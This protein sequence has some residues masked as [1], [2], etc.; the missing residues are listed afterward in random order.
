VD[1]YHL[2]C[3]VK[4]L[5][6]ARSPRAEFTWSCGADSFEPIVLDGRCVR[7]FREGADKARGILRR[8]VWA[9]VPPEAERDRGEILAAARE[10]A[11][12]G[13]EFYCLI[14]PDDG[15]EADVRGWLEEL[16]RAGKVA[17]IE[18]VCD[19]A[20]WSAPWNLVYGRDPEEF[21]FDATAGLAP[22]EPFWGIGYNLASGLPVNPLRSRPLPASP[23]VLLVIDPTVE[24]PLRD[25]TDPAGVS[26]YDHLAAFIEAALASGGRVRKVDSRDALKRALKAGRP[27]VMYWLCH[28]DPAMLWLGDDRITLTDLDNLLR[29]SLKVERNA[30]GLV[31]L[32]ACQTAPTDTEGLGSFLQ[33][34]HDRGYSGI[35]ATEEQTL[36]TFANPF[37]LAL[38]RGFL[39]E[40]QPIGPLLRRLRRNNVPLG[41][42]YGTYCPSHL[43]IARPDAPAPAAEALAAVA[44]PADKPA[45]S[46]GI[47]APAVA[48]PA[49]AGV[50][51]D[52]D[53]PLPPDPYLPLG[54]YGPEHRALFVGR[55]DDVERFAML[56]DHP[57]TRV[58]LLHG[59]SGAGKSSFLRAGVIPYLERDCIG[60]RFLRESAADPRSAVVF[61]RSTH[62]P[63]GQLAEALARFCAEP[64]TYRTPTGQAVTVDL[65]S[66]LDRAGVVAEA[67][68]LRRGILAD[69]DLLVDVLAALSSA[70]P[71]TPVIVVDQAEEMFTL[72]ESGRGDAT[73]EPML[74]AIR[75]IAAVPGDFKLILALRTEYHGRLVDRIS[76]GVAETQG[77]REYLLTD[78]DKEELAAAILRPTATGKVPHSG[79]VPFEVYHFR[80]ADGVAEEIASDLVRAGRRDG[81]LPLAQFVCDQ[82]YRLV[83]DRDDPTVTRSDYRDPPIRGLQGGLRR[84]LERQIDRIADGD[85]REK[86]ALWELLA[87]LS[88]PQVDGTMTTAL[89][90][91]ATLAGRWRGRGPFSEMLAK[92]EA[93][94]LLRVSARRLDDGTEERSVSLGHDALARVAAARRSERERQAQLDRE[95]RKRLRWAAGAA[96]GAVLAVLFLVLG[97]V[98]LTLKERADARTRDARISKSEAQASLGV[99]CR[100]LDEM[101]TR[102]ADVDL[103]DI[104]EME[105]TRRLLLEEA[106]DRY[107]N[108]RR[109]RGAERDPAMRRVA[110]RAEARLGDIQALLGDDEKAE[111]SYRG[112]IPQLAALLAE[113]LGDRDVLRNLVRCRLGLGALLKDEDRLE[114]AG[115]ELLEAGAHRTPLE[116]SGVPDDR[117]LL[118]EIDYQY[119]V[120]LTREADLRGL[121]IPPGSASEEAYQKAIRVQEGLVEQ[122]RG[123]T[124]RQ[125]KLGRYLNNLGKLLV[126]GQRF[127]EAEK[128]FRRAIELVGDPDPRGLPGRRWQYA[129]N[130]YNLGTLLVRRSEAVAEGLELM[131]KAKG[132]L[133]RL[134]EEFPDVPQYRRELALICSTLG[135][136]LSLKGQDDEARDDFKLAVDRLRRLVD[137]FPKVPAY[138][139]LYARTCL[140]RAKNLGQTDRDAAR[141]AASAAIEQLEPMAERHPDVPAYRVELGRASARLAW[142]LC[143]DH[144]AEARAPA[145]RAVREHTAAVESNPDSPRYRSDLWEDKYVLSEVLLGL[146]EIEPAARAAEELPRLLPDAIDSYRFAVICLTGCAGASKG[147]GP[148]YQAR[149]VRV[150]RTAVD[151]RMIRDPRELEAPAFRAL[152]GREDFRRLKASLASPRV[153]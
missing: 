129:R 140:L 119:G 124:E 75:R 57:Q 111:D 15:P 24:G 86:D 115:A 144:P 147:G 106:R 34:F 11:C 85:G 120:V 49:P 30:R 18:I 134:G 29:T 10:L 54:A 145:E 131:R 89:V 133:M 113:S 47:P 21:A 117:Q 48:G 23:D 122:E 19:G 114:E 60:Y 52:D 13:W 53:R 5:D 141:A 40:K 90:G 7:E 136:I 127:D 128:C 138:R 69:P 126:A 104:P 62:D 139:I 33:S 108:L 26:E 96:G 103:A 56:L 79:Q 17:G 41:L 153:D 87:D 59:E 35:V 45:V 58:L 74:D 20:P 12:T 72:A 107:D 78:L 36:D 143:E 123:R 132:L 105:R 148:D 27:D 68:A 28:A 82:L 50:A 2:I 99:A 149:A 101:L 135:R 80:Y 14:L 64:Y 38:L 16:T 70:L 146:G 51:G 22:F 142:I 100:G 42:V 83:K 97:L 102:V 37:G 6:D 116:A 31:I 61:V 152:E 77:V 3:R 25:Y 98:A 32:N 4:Q 76:R 73:G 112:V 130:A 81:V 39:D 91:V 67:G 55:E 84:H 92:A 94:R 65:R 44:L 66:C 109:Q 88:L 95:R 1:A 63:V 93:L 110:A 137:L 9:H 46:L 43:A 150:L 151:R 71:F 8:L 125:A 121:A 118:G